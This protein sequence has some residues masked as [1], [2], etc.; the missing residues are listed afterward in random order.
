MTPSL[1]SSFTWNSTEDGGR[2]AFSLLVYYLY[3][4]ARHTS[5]FPYSQVGAGTTETKNGC[6]G[7]VEYPYSLIFVTYSLAID[8]GRTLFVLLGKR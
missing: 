7:V 2:K 8:Q 3:L 6:S 1:R 5:V 4:Y